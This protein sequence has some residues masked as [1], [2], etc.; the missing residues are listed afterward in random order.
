MTVAGIDLKK[1]GN[2]SHLHLEV[3]ASPLVGRRMPQHRQWNDSKTFRIPFYCC[4]FSFSTLELHSRGGRH[5]YAVARCCEP[6]GFLG[7]PQ[8]FAPLQ[9]KLDF[10]DILKDLHFTMRWTSQ[11]CLETLKV[12]PSVSNRAFGNFVNPRS[13]KHL[14]ELGAPTSCWVPRWATC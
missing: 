1:F 14:V 11:V 10:L 4:I 2:I 9:E 13:C 3:E 8:A 12:S 5:S 7:Q 6:G